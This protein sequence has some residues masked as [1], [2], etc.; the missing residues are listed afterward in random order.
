MNASQKKDFL[1][2]AAFWS[3]ILFLAYFGLK[4]TFQ[5]FWPFL[6]GLFLAFLLHPAVNWISRFSSANKS[7]WSVAILLLLYFVLGLFLWFLCCLALTGIQNL[8]EFLPRV[9]REQIEPF[10]LLLSEHFSPPGARAAA[11]AQN[12]GELIGQIQKTLVEY[13]G[14]ALSIIS[15]WIAKAPAAFTAFLFTVLS[16]FMISMEYQNISRCIQR[17]M[18]RP[19]HRMLLDLKDFIFST[20]F[21]MLKAYT[22]LFIIT[23]LELTLGLWILKV[24]N[25]W[26]MALLVAAAD[27]LPIVGPGIVLVPWAVTCCISGNYF[28]G[29]GLL[30]LFGIVSLIRTII[31]PKIIGK[32]FGLHPLATI[33]AMYAGAQLWGIWGFFLAP[34]IVLYFLHWKEKQN[35][36]FSFKNLF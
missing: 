11:S 26:S 15:S 1:L 5:L 13:S 14:K 20:L 3:V 10:L 28:Q 27:A 30:A 17:N 25:F 33:T 24:E 23:F 29:I 4:F 8:L 35:W 6:A 2:S 32:Q 22:I 19:V 12:S 36:N 16:S 31:E 18:P 34:V 7:F 21:Q 9:Y